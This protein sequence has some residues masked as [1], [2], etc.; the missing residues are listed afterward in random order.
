VRAGVLL[1]DPGGLDDEMACLV[2]DLRELGQ[3]VVAGFLGILIGIT[4]CAGDHAR[5]LQHRTPS[6][7]R[8]SRPTG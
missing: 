1:I 2:N 6:C 8:R 3:T 4:C 5:D 7:I